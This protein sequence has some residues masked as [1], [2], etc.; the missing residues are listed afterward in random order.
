MESNGKP[1]LILEPDAA[2]AGRLEDALRGIGGFALTTV[3]TLKE[4]C[5][6]LVEMPFTLAFVPISNG[7]R[8]IRSLRAV[9]SDLRIILMTPTVTDSIHEKYAGR[10]QGLLIKP[11]LHVELPD[12][13]RQSFTNPLV[14]EKGEVEETRGLASMDTADV[15]A[16]LRQ[17]RLDRLLI[18]VIFA[19]GQKII[20]FWGELKEPE[21]AAIALHVGNGWG[22][23]PY[24]SRVQFF[25]LPARAGDFLLYTEMVTEEYL[26]TMVALPEAPLNEVRH[27]TR[28]VVKK[29]E[30]LA[31]GR[32][33]GVTGLIQQFREAGARPS[34]ALVWRPLKPVPHPLLI[35]LRRAYERLATPMAAC[36]PMSMC[37]KI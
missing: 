30:N 31:L 32:R 26:I 7:E 28:R 14:E 18:A 11:L 12:L 3:S 8:S 34:F 25:N 24:P 9:Q 4:A 2:F 22:K 36:S 15:L 21:A 37:A 35:P 10:I 16:V 29:L 33:F 5:L 13:L 19:Q 27:Q 6:Q 23:N 1:L 17:A 20:G